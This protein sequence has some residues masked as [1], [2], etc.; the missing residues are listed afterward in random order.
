M[1]EPRKPEKRVSASRTLY[2]KGENRIT[3]KSFGQTIANALA[4]AKDAVQKTMIESRRDIFRRVGLPVVSGALLMAPLVHPAPALAAAQDG[5]AVPA[6]G[7]TAAAASDWSQT[8]LASS[9]GPVNLFA[10]GLGILGNVS[11]SKDGQPA[12]DNQN[13]AKAADQSQAQQAKAADQGQA[14]QA[15]QAKA[16]DQSQAQQAQTAVAKPAPKVDASSH[17]GDRTPDISTPA[18]FIAAVAP[19]AQDSQ[20]E[21]GVPASVT[22]AQAILES[23]WGRSALSTKAQN[24]FGI[25]AASGPGPAGVINMDT[26]EVVGGQNVTINDGFKAYHNLWESVMDHGH[27]L[28]DNPRYADAFKTTNPRTFAQ[29][30]HLDGYA[31][32]PSYSTK[33]GNLIDTYHL[34]QYDLK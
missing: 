30:I 8:P 34:D 1:I 9:Q 23:D 33:L 19:A 22:I 29:R 7:A 25:K 31:T 20:R 4:R 11:V 26:W 2:N 6:S 12:A 18:K 5:S 21:S 14:Q 17:A 10:P 16:A 32:D 13:A 24:Y 3:A 27:F 15:Q 28:R